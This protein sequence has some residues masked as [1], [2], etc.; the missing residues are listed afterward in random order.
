MSAQAASLPPRPRTH[1]GQGQTTEIKVRGI[2]AALAVTLK[3]CTNPALAAFPYWH[4]DLNSGSGYNHDAGCFGSP[5]AF[6]AAVSNAGKANY[7]AFFCDIRRDAVFEL[8]RLLAP[9]PG[10]TCLCGNNRAVLPTVA[11]TIRTVERNPHLA[12]GTVLCD[13]NGYFYGD[14]VPAEEL[15]QFCIEFPRIDV[16]LNL[17]VTTRRWIRGRIEKRMR[18]WENAICLRLDEL[19]AFLSRRHWLIRNLVGRGGH[20]F[21]LMVGRNYQLGDHRAMGFFHLDSQEGQEIVAQV[22]RPRNPAIQVQ[23]HSIDL[24]LFSGEAI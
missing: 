18:G 11:K 20:Q 23:R 8:K 12:M 24:P 22:E 14:S 5:L 4:I 7:R 19:P 13:P 9:E 16:I 3:I 15:R 1:Q 6:L 21:V 17:N 10:C 2:G